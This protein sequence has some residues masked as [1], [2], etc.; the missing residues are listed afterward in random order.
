MSK[1]RRR[2]IRGWVAKRA[3]YG[4]RWKGIELEGIYKTKGDVSEWGEMD[5]PPRKVKVTIEEV[6]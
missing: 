3:K 2:V 1:M 6:G 5:W 4:P